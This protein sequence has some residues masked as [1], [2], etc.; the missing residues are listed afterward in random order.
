M[1]LR[2][3]INSCF[4]LLL[5]SAVFFSSCR[6]SSGDSSLPPLEPLALLSSDLSIYVNVPV[7]KHQ[8]LTA[9]I[10]SAEVPSI[11]RKD[12]LSLASRIGHLYAG[13]GQVTDRS[14]L[15]MACDADIPSFAKRS[16][17][18]KK[19][20]WKTETYKAEGNEYSIEQ[21]YPRNFNVMTRNEIDFALSFPD[22]DVLCVSKDIVPLLENAA[23]RQKTAPSPYADWINRESDDILFYITRS[24]QYLNSLLGAKVTVST[25][26]V[27]GSIRYTPDPKRK[28]VYSGLY[29][30]TF[31]V[32][33]K[34][35]RTMSAFKS[36]LSL[37]F[38]LMGAEIKQ[39][40]ECTV[41]VS[42]LEI[43]DKQIEDLFTRDPITGKH[44][45][46]EGDR[47]ITEQVPGKK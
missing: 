19:N 20:G 40:E 47:I 37:A 39:T 24:G 23:L 25:D 46:V 33:L 18:S 21:G 44:Y 3:V 15:E 8:E 32:H 35:K 5:S 36:M 27:Y 43:T 6:S 38:G 22:E 7:Q 16:V 30:L 42:G 34:D 12:A 31:C 45:R 9:R 4:C 1:K 2:S 28:G 29:D 14:Y 11:S 10:L 26:Y 13:L 41:Q 17:F